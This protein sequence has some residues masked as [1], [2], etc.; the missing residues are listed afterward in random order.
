MELAEE[1][2][3]GGQGWK[4]R[5]VSFLHIYQWNLADGKV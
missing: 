3:G 1:G 4:I 5:L 2:G